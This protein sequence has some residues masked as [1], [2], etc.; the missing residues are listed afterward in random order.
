MHSPKPPQQREEAEP[1]AHSARAGQPRQRGSL[2]GQVMVPDSFFDPLPS[3]ELDLWG[4]EAAADL[5]NSLSR[6]PNQM[7]R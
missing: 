3:S 2:Q 5:P 6:S 4:Q 7:N 1:I